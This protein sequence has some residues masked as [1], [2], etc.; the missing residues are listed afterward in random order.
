MEFVADRVALGHVSVR[1]VHF[2]PVSY[3]STDGPYSTAIDTISSKTRTASLNKPYN[4]SYELFCSR[5]YLNDLCTS[6][7]LLILHS[8]INVL[9]VVQFV[10]IPNLR[11]LMPREGT[12]SV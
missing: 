4:T 7:K 3:H 2:Y 10:H 1:V 9:R 6:P 11:L 5:I 12:G 8:A